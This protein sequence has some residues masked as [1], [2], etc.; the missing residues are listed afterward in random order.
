MKEKFIISTT[1]NIEHGSI[2]QYID[3]VCSNIVLGTNLFSD[4]AA[5]FTD[6]FGGKSES[7]Q[8]KLE[9]IYKESKKDLI[10]KAIKIGA[11]AIIGFKLDFDEISGKDKSMLMVSAS[12]TACKIKYDTSFKE[13][14]LST[15]ISQAD[16]ENEI[17][18]RFV[19][20]EVL[21]GKTLE[22]DWIEL[23]I[24]NP[25]AEVIEKLARLYLESLFKYDEEQIK[26]IEKVIKAYPKALAVSI[27]YKL[28]GECE[29]KDLKEYFQLIKNC[30]L[31]D[32]SS[33]LE[34]CTKN[35]HKGLLLLLIKSDLYNETDIATMNR[36][37]TFL[38]NLPDTGTIERVTTGMFSKKEEDKF[39]CEKGHKNATNK[40]F[41]GT[42]G[43]NIKGIT[44]A[45]EEQIQ[46]FKERVEIL[47]EMHENIK[48]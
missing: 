10:S 40:I 23:L 46:T 27:L 13:T 20:K 5:S 39:I 17:K 6:F 31:F 36:L 19:I 11:N 8:R 47:N 26:M 35:L 4:F 7:Y 2:E 41:C 37:C 28:Y 42:C 21:N 16:L 48:K 34:L 1:N 18:K 44:H 25:H 32:A 14:R 29:D 45:E 43:L 22:E 12:G 9:L 15:Y 33:I 30:H 38:D 3:I 24:E